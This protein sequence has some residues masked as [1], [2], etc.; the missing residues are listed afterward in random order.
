MHLVKLACDTD[1]PTPYEA[2]PDLCT[3]EASP[4]PGLLSSGNSIGKQAREL[5]ILR[6][7]GVSCFFYH[8]VLTELVS[9]RC[10]CLPLRET[11]RC[12]VGMKEIC[13]KSDAELVPLTIEPE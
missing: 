11:R 8:A 9:V 13:L 4:L 3:R 2:F 7:C 6:I 10:W 1:F 12:N 5:S